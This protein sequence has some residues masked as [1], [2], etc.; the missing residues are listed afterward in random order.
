M[1]TRAKFPE[2]RKVRRIDHEERVEAWRMLSF[3]QQLDSLASR[4]GRSQ[5][6]VVR[7]LKAI[8]DRDSKPKTKKKEKVLA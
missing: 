1:T 5:K 8:A 3:E 2:R 6:Q 7:I 4:P